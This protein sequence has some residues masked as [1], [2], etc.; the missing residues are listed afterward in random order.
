MTEHLVFPLI[1]TV[2]LQGLVTKRVGFALL[3]YAN[4]VL[5]VHQHFLDMAFFLQDFI[6]EKKHTIHEK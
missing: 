1:P 6:Q 2:P 4:F 5:N 3:R